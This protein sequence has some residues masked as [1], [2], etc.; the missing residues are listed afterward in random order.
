MPDWLWAIIGLV[1]AGLVGLL[2]YELV[3]GGTKQ[4]QSGCAWLIVIAAGFA[5]YAIGGALLSGIASVLSTDFGKWI[6]V[7]VFV[8]MGYFGFFYKPKK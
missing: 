8:A 4:Q 7:A 6:L 1:A 3:T 5:L 2:C